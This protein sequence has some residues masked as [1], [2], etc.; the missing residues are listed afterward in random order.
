MV[1]LSTA[2]AVLLVL[3]IV[4]CLALNLVGLPGN[5]IAVGLAASY[6]YFVADDT[7]VDIGLATVIG[8]LI[9]AAIG[10]A[11]EFLAAALGATKAGGSKRGAVLALG[12]SLGGGFIGLFVPIPIPVVGSVIGA[13]VFASIGALFGAVLGE[14][15]KGRDL[16]ESLKVGHAAFWGR[17]FGTLGKVLVGCWMLLL[18][19]SALFFG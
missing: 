19:V 7:R 15:W 6:A 2:L 4:V 13:L 16:D 14:Q 11:I 9:L 5:W 10:E 3:A 8:L 17:L 1:I 18:V 12:G